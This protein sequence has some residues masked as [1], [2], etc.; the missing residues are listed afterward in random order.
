MQRSSCTVDIQGSIGNIPWYLQGNLSIFHKDVPF[1]PCWNISCLGSIFL[2]SLASISARVQ[3]S[4]SVADGLE[5]EQLHH[6]HQICW[7]AS[8]L[9]VACKNWAL[10]LLL[11]TWHKP[12]LNFIFLHHWQRECKFLILP[13]FCWTHFLK[14]DWIM[15]TISISST[16]WL[17]QLWWLKDSVY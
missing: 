10:V 17:A 2:Y 1:L 15:V 6:Y 12:K 16:Q 11:P 14:H 4:S 7:K 3:Y 13:S 9:Q 8:I 5:V